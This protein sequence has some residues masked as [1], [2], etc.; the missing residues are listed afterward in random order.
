[1]DALLDAIDNVLTALRGSKKLGD[2]TLAIRAAVAMVLTLLN[3]E[4]TD[5][6]DP[7]CMDEGGEA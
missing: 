6:D 5:C 7:T 2:K 1:M 4:I 3:C